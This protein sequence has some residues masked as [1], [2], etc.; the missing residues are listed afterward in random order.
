MKF[1]PSPNPLKGGEIFLQ[2]Q[3]A[4]V[5]VHVLQQHHR[6]S[7]KII[8][9]LSMSS[10]APH[11]VKP[12]G[13]ATK[14]ANT[15]TVLL[16]IASTT[17]PSK[18]CPR[19][20]AT[21]A[22]T[23]AMNA[24]TVVKVPPE[25]NLPLEHSEGSAE[26]A[27]SELPLPR[28]GLRIRKATVLRDASEPLQE[29]KPKKVLA[30]ETKLEKVVKDERMRRNIKSLALYE[31]RVQ[32]MG[33]EST[34]LP[35]PPGATSAAKKI[36]GIRR[37]EVLEV[38]GDAMDVDD[39]YGV[40]DFVAE[41]EKVD[42]DPNTDE[43]DECE[44]PGFHRTARTTGMSGEERS[45]EE[46]G[47]LYKMDALTSEADALTSSPFKPSGNSTSSEEDVDE[48]P[49]VRKIAERKGKAKEVARV[50]GKGEQ[51]ARGKIADQ[52]VKQSKKT[53]GILLRE[54]ITASRDHVD[55]GSAV[56]DGR[57]KFTV[58]SDATSE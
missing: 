32:D 12:K 25:E 4:L 37:P 1:S 15:N 31:R 39:E 2:S 54:T 55:S 33:F 53:R 48:T 28:R 13:K 49:I 16:D 20:R 36:P 43:D 50:V 35:P 45:G 19:P 14:T 40:E 47:P 17:V 11:K 52:K 3:F 6:H 42:D 44:F 5:S 58:N 30:A 57:G 22:N 51:G 8:V 23:T 18:A 9:V 21:T 29:K 34:P 7:P 10:N 26:L 41:I 56:S 38:A 46:D 24:Q 27:L